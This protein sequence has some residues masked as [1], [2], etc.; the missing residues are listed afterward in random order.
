MVTLPGDIVATL[1]KTVPAI[2]ARIK[3]DPDALIASSKK[4][5]STIKGKM[6]NAI[7]SITGRKKP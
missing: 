1:K 4:T 6:I 7:D 3:I 5:I 2:Q